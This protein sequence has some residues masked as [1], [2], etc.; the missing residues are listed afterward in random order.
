M[1]EKSTAF[2]VH[3]GDHMAPAKHLQEAVWVFCPGYGLQPN[4]GSLSPVLA[5]LMMDLPDLLVQP[6]GS[7]DLQE[8]HG[9]LQLG[10]VC[11]GWLLL[12]PACG[13]LH[14]VVLVGE[15]GDVGD[16]GMKSRV[17]TIQLAKAELPNAE[18]PNAELLNTELP[19][20]NY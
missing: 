4:L 15:D 13:H 16:V 10:H 8:A 11:P 1:T 12:E 14:P 5:N 7:L 9:C 19:N 17:P 6:H 3:L 20:A 18:L 2:P